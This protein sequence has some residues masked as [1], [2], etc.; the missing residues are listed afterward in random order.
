MPLK[1]KFEVEKKWNYYKSA[2]T[3]DGVDE[4]NGWHSACKNIT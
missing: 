1:G 3:I 2:Y 4:Q